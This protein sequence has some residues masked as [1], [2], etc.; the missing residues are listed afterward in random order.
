MFALIRSRIAR[1]RSELLTKWWRSRQVKQGVKIH[2][3]AQFTGTRPIERYLSVG[4]GTQICIGVELYIDH[5]LDRSPSIKIG[6]G[7]Y[8]GQYSN[9]GAYAPVMV[10]NDVMIGPFCHI[11]SGDH[12]F[13][14]RDV[15]MKQQGHSGAS[16]MIEDDV[17]LGSHVV[18]LSGVTIGKGA[19][20]AAGG[21]VT[22][23]IPPYE[24]W[25]GVPAKFLKERP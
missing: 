14:R 8:V 18:V 16:V 7:T 10:G 23:S 13:D 1:S 5:N 21:V 6:R 9:I 22:K 15:P 2:P 25:G 11:V 12:R 24:I 19:I 17:W 20:V 4:E 3:Q